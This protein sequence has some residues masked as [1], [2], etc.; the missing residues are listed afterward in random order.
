MGLNV[1]DK[2]PHF[3]AVDQRGETFD[4]KTLIGKKIVVLYFYPKNFTPVCTA[5]ACSFRDQYED[6]TDFGAEVIGV[7]AD[8][9]SSHQKF[10]KK[11]TIPFL[12]LS[13]KDRALAK[14]F[15]VTSSLLGLLPARETFVID[16]Q[17]VVRLRFSSMGAKE[18]IR[19]A[20]KV[21]KNLHE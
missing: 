6:F 10:S 2:T 11:Y 16:R 20:L 17:G 18:H 3:I 14:K 4:S 5:E 21:V 15:G 7:S 13:D 9:P 1:G 19:K 8:K 12:F